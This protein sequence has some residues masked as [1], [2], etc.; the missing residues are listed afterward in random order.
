MGK[1]Q[2]PTGKNAFFIC[3]RSGRKFPY[4]LAVKEPGTGYIVHRRESDGAYNIVDHPQNYPPADLTEAI[5]VRWAHPDIDGQVENKVF[6]ATPDG[7]D[8]IFPG[9]DMIGDAPIYARVSAD[10]AGT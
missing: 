2:H 4:R 6:L 5:A 8:I 3:D 1:R 9:V 7:Q 10:V